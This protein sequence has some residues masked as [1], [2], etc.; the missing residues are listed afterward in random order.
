MA[1]WMDLQ[2]PIM[3]LVQIFMKLRARRSNTGRDNDKH[4][5]KSRQFAAELKEPLFNAYSLT[6]LF[7]LWVQTP[8]D[9]PKGKT[10][11]NVRLSSHIM[12]ADDV[13]QSIEKDFLNYINSQ[14]NTKIRKNIYIYNNPIPMPQ[15][16]NSAVQW[17]LSLEHSLS[18]L[19]SQKPSL[20]R[21]SQHALRRQCYNT[22]YIRDQTRQAQICKG[23]N[24]HRRSS[25]SWGARRAPDTSIPLHNRK[26]W[27]H[28][29]EQP[30]ATTYFG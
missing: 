13:S 22:N 2:F 28:I 12:F 9:G 19:W 30:K 10:W 29:S 3:T 21:G 27:N 8:L 16:W 17:L 26:H 20:T 6:V 4:M 15:W 23:K 14:G 25:F 5:F 18:H 24:T 11:N 1:G 7:C